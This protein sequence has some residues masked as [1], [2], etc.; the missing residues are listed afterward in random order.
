MLGRLGGS[1]ARCPLE[2]RGS[3]EQ[4]EALRQC[5]LRLQQLEAE[6]AAPHDEPMREPHSHD[7]A[8]ARMEMCSQASVGP[9]L[10]TLS[11]EAFSHVFAACSRFD[12]DMPLFD[13]VKGLAC[14]CKGMLLQLHRLRPLVGVMSLA[15]VHRQGARSR[16]VR[17]TEGP[18]RV[19]LLYKGKL[20]LP[21]VKLAWQGRVH[22]I[23]A[24]FC[25]SHTSLAVALTRR[26]VPMLMCKGCSLIELDVSGVRLNGTWASAFGEVAEGSAVL[27][28][29]RL[30]GCGLRGPLPDLRLPALQTLDMSCNE[31]TGGLEPL[32]GS[33]AL[34]QLD[35]SFNALTGGLEPLQR[36]TALQTLYLSNNQLA[37]ELE[38]LQLCAALLQAFCR[39]R[40]SAQKQRSDGLK[41][42]R[43]CT[44]LQRLHLQNNRLAPTDEDMA[45]FER[46]CRRQAP[47]SW[48]VLILEDERKGVGEAGTPSTVTPSV[49]P[50]STPSTPKMPSM[51]PMPPMPSTPS[52]RA[53]RRR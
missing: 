38:P 30:S 52:S 11:D 21:V 48:S 32:Q 16:R 6:K 29:L 37:A 50:S 17:V 34:Q 47:S 51:P 31:L 42:L 39:S 13:A 44:A 36:C 45:Y 10:V 4:L 3:A 43:G 22:S 9:T 27:R 19:T 41:P 23:D 40:G 28:R 18:W 25:P 24:R 53:R 14:V 49:T 1:P 20:T 26:T 46:Q 35:L 12:H 2:R 33:T 15:A 7:S 8:K 5:E